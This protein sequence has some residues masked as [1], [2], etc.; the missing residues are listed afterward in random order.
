MQLK[1]CS[2]IVTTKTSTFSRG[3]IAL[4]IDTW[5]KRE[6]VISC[7]AVFGRASGMGIGAL[8]FHIGKT[9]QRRHRQVGTGDSSERLSKGR[10]QYI[11]PAE[12]L[13]SLVQILQRDNGAW[14]KALQVTLAFD[15][16]KRIL[17]DLRTPHLSLVDLEQTRQTSI[18]ENK[19]AR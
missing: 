15:R 13:I 9:C 4:Q 14:P 6:A 19:Q 12:P 16:T 2:V 11:N 3:C 5:P 8:V 1:G 17:C 10:G 7:K 18:L